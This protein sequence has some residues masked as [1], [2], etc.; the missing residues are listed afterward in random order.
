MPDGSPYV[1]MGRRHS[2]QHWTSL[3]TAH[4]WNAG[5]IAAYYLDGYHRGL[6]VAEMTGD[7][8]V[9]RVFGEHGTTGR[10]LYLS[11]WN[12][13]EIWDATKKDKYRKELEDRVDIMLELQKDADQA[14]S[15]VMDRY[16]YTNVYASNGL[17][18]FYQMTGDGVVKDA[19]VKH[20]RRV[21]DLAP[22]NHDMESYLSSISSL[23]VGYE[24]SEEE[25]FLDEAK[26]R[27]RHLKTDRLPRDIAEYENQQVLA[28]ALESVSQLPDDE[29]GWRP[30]IW[31]ISNGLRVFGWTHIY[32][33]PWLLYWLDG[34]DELS[35][36]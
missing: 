34:D 36:Q 26:N 15:L 32:N 8:Y 27:A 4:V 13:A 11:V 21:R 25:S 23:V 30:A 9:K 29:G 5:W 2:D 17:R 18:K 3:L 24:L 22:Y 12:L 28:E 20:A 7:Y 19:L 14:G 1:G 10:R 6:E 35:G 16:G 31:K 33:V